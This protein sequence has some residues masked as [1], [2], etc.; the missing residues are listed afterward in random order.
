M[1][2][3]EYQELDRWGWECPKCKD[4]NETEED[5][6]YQKPCIECGET[7]KHLLGCKTPRLD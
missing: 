6:A 4:W 1:E 2:E 5:P 3:V 7:G